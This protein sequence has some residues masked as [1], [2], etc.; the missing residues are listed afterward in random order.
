MTLTV[1]G[2]DRASSPAGNS[3]DK[4]AR[5]YAVLQDFYEGVFGNL[6]IHYP[7]WLPGTRNNGEGTNNSNRYMAEACGVQQ[8]QKILDAGCGLGASAFWLAEH[9]SVQVFALSI[10]GSNIARC[11][12]V[13]ERRQLGHLV[14]FAV[15]NF[16]Q[17]PFPNNTFDVVWNLESFNYARPKK[18]YIE[19]VFQLLRPGGAWVCLDGFIDG[20]QC[21]SGRNARK[22]ARINEGFAHTPEHWEGVLAIM[23][24]MGQAGFK[25][26]RYDDL[27]RYVTAAPRRGFLTDLVACLLNLKDLAAGREVYLARLKV[28]A[29]VYETWRL[30]QEKVL[31]YGLLFGRKP[32]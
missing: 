26:V 8:T 12:E 14:K 5:H 20:S 23:Q 15:A 2:A 10:C 28:F 31:S 21:R 24:Y 17:P 11:R 16:M 3:V 32:A 6:S 7:L 9:Y 18:S 22:L 29:A 25:D 13:S 30:M 1:Q 27:T 4:V 19:K